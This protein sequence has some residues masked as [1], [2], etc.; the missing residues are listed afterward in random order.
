[1]IVLR[2]S[3]RSRN[4]LSTASAPMCRSIS[5]HFIQTG[6][7][8]MCLERRPPR[9][10]LREEL[11]RAPAYVTFTRAMFMTRRGRAPIVTP[12]AQALSAGTGTRS[13]PGRSMKAVAAGAAGLAAQAFSKK[14]LVRGARG[15][16]QS[17]L[18]GQRWPNL[19]SPQWAAIRRERTC[20]DAVQSRRSQNMS[21]RLSRQRPVFV[22][23][24]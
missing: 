23:L 21:D 5:L 18:A 6:G 10:L 22:F 20:A 16:C 12:A 14:D 13:P 4:G 7:C 19:C 1:M 11:R 15:G 9:S 24:D 2:R 17:S 8:A 3:L